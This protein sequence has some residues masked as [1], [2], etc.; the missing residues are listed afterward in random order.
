MVI[1]TL[2]AGDF[3]IVHAAFLEAFSDYVVPLSPPR[4]QLLE[5]L[6]RRAWHPEASVGM[7][8]GERLVAFTLNGIDGNAGYD[9]GTGVVPSHRQ[10]GLA[11]TMM[12]RSFELLR[13]RGCTRYVLE[14]IDSNTRAIELYRGLG[15]VERRGLQCWTFDGGGDAVTFDGSGS[16]MIAG[17]IEPPWQNTPASISRAR[18]SHVTL[19]DEHAVAVL[20]PGN[21]DLPHLAVR[22]D[23][24]R[25][26]LGTLLLKA[27]AHRAGKPLRIMNVDERDEGIA[28]FLEQVGAKKMV[29][30]LEMVRPL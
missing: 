20:F 11:R 12:E 30:Q 14:V 6:T 2:T 15:F 29:R 24:R 13:E 17:D 26:G 18:D 5:M 27:A 4:E 25:R 21:G 16:T 8:D 7:F 19:G 22:Q 10:R 1:R 3:E 28:R 23:A 9:S